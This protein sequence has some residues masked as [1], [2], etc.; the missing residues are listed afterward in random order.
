[1][2]SLARQLQKLHQVCHREWAA[3]ARSLGLS[4]SEF[5]YL[6]AV[7]E[8]ADL[9]HFENA[10]GQHLQDIVGT[11]GVSKASASAMIGKLEG[12]NLVTRFACKM[13][14]RAHHIVLTAEGQML[15]ARGA[16]VYERIAQRLD[17]GLLADLG[18]EGG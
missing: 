1:M 3:T 8:Q 4:F 6:N 9:Q 5:E 17:E 13:D 18:V 7:Q 16:R 14:A 11:L 15:L 10:H 12:R 2:S